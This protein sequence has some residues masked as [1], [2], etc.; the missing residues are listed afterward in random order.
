MKKSMLTIA[1]ISCLFQSAFA[2]DAGSLVGQWSIQKS[3]CKSGTQMGS[4]YLEISFTA[5]VSFNQDQT[6]AADMNVTAVWSKSYLAQTM[7]QMAAYKAQIDAIPAGTAGKDA[8]LDAYNKQ[9]ASIQQQASQPMICQTKSSGT[10]SVIDDKLSTNMIADANSCSGGGSAGGGNMKDGQVVIQGDTMV[11][12]EPPIPP[13]TPAS[14][15]SGDSV[16]TT[17]K[18]VLK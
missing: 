15:P 10:Y 1:V 17:L 3:E 7:A 13:L 11:L 18:R 2:V 12:T 16:V 4:G 8:M 14:C 5:T 9:M 6:I